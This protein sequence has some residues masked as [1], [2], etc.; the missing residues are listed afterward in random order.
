[1]K[2]HREDL[3]IRL[4]EERARL[5]FSQADFANKLGVSREGVRLYESGQRGISGE[6]LAQTAELGVDVQ[7]VL[8]GVRSLNLKEV[9]GATTHVINQTKNSGNVIGLVQN[10]ATVHQI[11][12]NRHVTTTVAEV[13]P[14]DEH[15]SEE[16]ASVL[17][18]LVR[19]NV[20]LEEKLKKTPRTHRAVWSGLNAYCKVTR[21][22]LIKKIDFDKARKYLDQS[23]G[24][25]NSMASAPVKD[26]DAWRKRH[27]A[28]I[29]INSRDSEPALLAYMKKNFQV[30][31]L[32]ELS[33]EHLAQVYKY[34]AGKKRK[35]AP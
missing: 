9:E 19:K 33:N 15:I 3:A 35:K 22:R 1:M 17:M 25:L 16:Q 2:N 20:E 4:I 8:S 23:I 28:Y 31:S 29:K 30:V 32:T 10:G 34:V 24:R 14:G 12:T 7:Y 18:E 11:N 21:Y 13:K 5:G 26:G 6:F 27:Y